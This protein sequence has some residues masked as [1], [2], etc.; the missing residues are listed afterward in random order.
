[1]KYLF[2]TIIVLY[3]TFLLFASATTYTPD[4]ETFQIWADAYGKKY[5]SDEYQKV[6]AIWQASVNQI[7]QVNSKINLPD[8][9]LDFG[10]GPSPSS[11]RKLY[12]AQAVDPIVSFPNA[13]MP[14]MTLGEF[15][16]MTYDS[17][18]HMFLGADAAAIPAT[19]AAGSALSTGAI[20]GIAIGGS[21]V[22]V[23]AAAG[24]AYAVIKSKRGKTTVVEVNNMETEK[25]K[26][27][28]IDVYKF[29]K[30]N[31]AHS[32]TARDQSQVVTQ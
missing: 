24:V 32:I 12:A 4:A 15:S 13:D 26:S 25:K 22:V 16:D 31:V 10:D 8:V 11:S 3:T 20:I 14:R 2:P 29:R 30:G 23:G 18:S 5:T 6:F 7:N 19:A 27:K 21:A 1:M 17:F 9:H 28:G